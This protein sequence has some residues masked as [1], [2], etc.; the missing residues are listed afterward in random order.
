MFFGNAKKVVKNSE[1]KTS[2]E[3]PNHL[4]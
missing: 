3:F 4:T 2:S 1:K